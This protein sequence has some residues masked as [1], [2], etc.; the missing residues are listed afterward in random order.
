MSVLVRLGV[1]LFAF[2]DT[3][4]FCLLFCFSFGCWVSLVNGKWVGFRFIRGIVNSVVSVQ[5]VSPGCVPLH[6]NM[7]FYLKSVVRHLVS[8]SVSW[9]SQSA[10]SAASC[11]TL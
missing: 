11:V 5:L 7:F 3:I 6:G 4:A 10:R 8:Y 9:G 1:W 2:C